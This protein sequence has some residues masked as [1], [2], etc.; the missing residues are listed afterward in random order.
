MALGT[1]TMTLMELTTA[2]AGVAGN[3][4]PVQPHAFVQ[5]EQGWWDWLWN[6][7]DSLSGGVHDDMQGLLRGA[8]N[9]GT[10]RAAMLSRPNFGKTGTTQDH[11][12]ALF[13]GY[14]GEGAD[15][16]VV[17]VWIGNDDNSPLNRV[18]GGTVP[19]RIWRDFMSGA[20][21]GDENRRPAPRPSANPSGPVQPQDVEG[22][23]DIPLT[24]DGNT[25][26]SVDS[27]GATISTGVEGVDV[28]IRLDE[29]GVS[30]SP[31]NGGNKPP[32]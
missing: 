16:L 27:G 26:L 11:R 30:V 32:P 20:L 23:E 8:I 18:S 1:S 12:D 3:A 7:P 21:G 31:G 10:G 22:L 15:R 9:H 4:F 14:A 17:G 29:Q 28:N 24:D 2:Y 6:G 25:R 13:V 5:P 19:A